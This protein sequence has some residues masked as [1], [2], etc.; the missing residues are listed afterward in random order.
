MR[1]II[2]PGHDRGC[3]TLV[4]TFTDERVRDLKIVNL[5]AAEIIAEHVSLRRDPV[6]IAKK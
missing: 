6:Q 2:A 4:I 3:D 5:R 1:P